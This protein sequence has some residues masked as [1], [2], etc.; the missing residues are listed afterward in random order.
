M[1]IE[2]DDGTLL[3]RDVPNNVP[4]AEWDGRV[5]EFR[6]QAY[7]YRA[8]LEWAGTWKHHKDTDDDGDHVSENTG[9]QATAQCQC[10]KSSIEIE[11]LARR[12]PDL[13]LDPTLQIEPRDYQQ[14]ALNAWR[15]H[16]RRG[17]VVFPTGSGKTFLGLQAIVDA[18][19]SALVAA[20]TIDLMNQWHATLTNAFGNQLP[21]IGV[22]GG[23]EHEIAELTVTTYD[24][25]YRYI[26]EYGDQFGLL[27]TD[28]NTSVRRPTA[29]SG[30]NRHSCLRR[31]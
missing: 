23:S 3:I 4:Y 12:Y 28:V 8:L 1:R 31:R 30:S 19:V 6:A 18:G 10:T 27:V 26:N 11:D 24:S 25:A 20:P 7:R 5:E 17:S 14:A 21:K 15:N 16:D 13:A 2:F 9:D 29:F 22:L